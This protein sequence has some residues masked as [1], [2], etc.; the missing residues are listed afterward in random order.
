MSRGKALDFPTINFDVDGNAAGATNATLP[1][2]IYRC[3]LKML[4][5]AS[6]E[7]GPFLGALHFGPRDTFSEPAPSFEVHLLEGI[8]QLPENVN[9]ETFEIDVR[10]RIRDT[11]KFS[12]AEELKKAIAADLAEIRRLSHNGRS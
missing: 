2:G 9:G 1:F 8:S 3:F 7:A 5:N 6:G 11:K 4:K 12:S 10:E